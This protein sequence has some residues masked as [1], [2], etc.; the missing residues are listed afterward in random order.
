MLLYTEDKMI[1]IIKFILYLIPIVFVAF[2][3]LDNIL[4]ESIK[5]K[6]SYIINNILNSI[7]RNK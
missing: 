5:S 4:M 3:I 1:E 6:Y 2:N 7:F